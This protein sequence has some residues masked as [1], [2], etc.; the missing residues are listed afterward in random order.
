VPCGGHPSTRCFSRFY[1]TRL[2][3]IRAEW[4]VL[5]YTSFG[6]GRR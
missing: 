1:Y 4:G 2:D 3:A 6:L 5:N